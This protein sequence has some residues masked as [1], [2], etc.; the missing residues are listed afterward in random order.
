MKQTPIALAVI[1]QL[2]A[3]LALG[4]CRRGEAT[5]PSAPPAGAAAVGVKVV[6]PRADAG[7]VMRA[8][9]E[10]RARNEAVLSAEASGRILRFHVDVGSRVHRGDVLMELDASGPRIA[11]Q[12]AQAARSAAEAARRSV[13][14][15]LRRTEELTRGGAASAATLEKL[16]IGIEQADAAV[17]QATAAAAAAED[18]L[19]KTAI[20]AP[21]DG[22]VTAR[23]K[24]A[25][26][27]VAMMPPTPVLAMVD[28]A[29][30]EVRVP[31]PESLVDLLAPGDE[32]EASVSP[33]GKPFR[34]RV[35]SI[36]SAVDA[37]AR[38]VDV[39]ADLVGATF[40]ELRPGAIVEVR[41]GKAGGVE[42]QG[43][44][45]PAEAV[46]DE[47]GKSY[48]WAV[49][50]DEAR[51][52]PVDV[53]RLT[54]GTVRV[55]SGLGPEDRVVADGGVGLTDGARVHVQQ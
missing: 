38:T 34:A 9:G 16:Q 14:A 1:A 27:Y 28:V 47:G 5:L 6:K 43:V 15:D 24:S 12:Q 45:L 40:R 46:R 18:Q 26:E 23:L 52:R 30:V 22:V 8:T 10:L 51:R 55:V 3:A 31:V 2:A 49:V 17:Q 21:F 33:S 37:G 25:G 20:R 13:A 7:T 35:R 54:P 29:T 42:A 48:V 36:G 4:G 50:S 39:R 19:A 41:L 53:Q 32:L 11:V 44:F